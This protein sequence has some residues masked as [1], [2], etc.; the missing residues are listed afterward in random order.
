MPMCCLQTKPIDSHLGAW[1]HSMVYVSAGV[2]KLPFASNS[3]Q[4]ISSM[5][6]LD[7]VTNLALGL[8]EMRRV[9]Q[10][11]G[12]FIVA[13][14]IHPITTPCEPLFLGWDFAKTVVN[15]G[16][17]LDRE[18]W[19]IY[20]KTL[21]VH[22]KSDVMWTDPPNPSSTVVEIVRNGTS[23]EHFGWF[24]GIFTKA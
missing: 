8:Q 1:A 22:S 12:K 5:N 19:W 20:K 11:G 15:N 7:H 9:L 10:P 21:G 23:K 2:E 13:V 3:F 6:N 18:R 24:V 4:I 14:E 17:T 16:F